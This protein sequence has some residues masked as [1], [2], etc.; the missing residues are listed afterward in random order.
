MTGV[1]TCALPI[2][3]IGEIPTESAVTI[4]PNPVSE[5]VTFTL[6]DKSITKIGRASCRERV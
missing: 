5:K 4:Y 6:Q 3:S 2:Y 1:Q